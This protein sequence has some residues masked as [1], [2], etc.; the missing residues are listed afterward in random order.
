MYFAM[1]DLGDRKSELEQFTVNAWRTPK[2]V[3]LAHR[4]LPPG[5]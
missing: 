2:W 5:Q 3:F 1:V 4:I